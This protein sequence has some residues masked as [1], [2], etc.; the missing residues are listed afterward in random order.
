MSESSYLEA[1]GL[2]LANKDDFG[3]IKKAFT[4][5]MRGQ[6]NYRADRAKYNLAFEYL[7]NRLFKVEENA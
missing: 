3:K 2:S 5:K 7:C 1:L 6:L 4:H